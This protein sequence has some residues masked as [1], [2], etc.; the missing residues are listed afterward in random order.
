VL[1]YSHEY[2]A[3]VY[4]SKEAAAVGAPREAVHLAIDHKRDPAARAKLSRLQGKYVYV[5]GEFAE[6]HGSL[7]ECGSLTAITRLDENL[8]A[9]KAVAELARREAPK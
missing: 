4:Y 5:R 9:E 7:W 3:F 8:G 6:T 2:G 1:Q